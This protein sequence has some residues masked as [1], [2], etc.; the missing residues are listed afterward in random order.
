MAR[1]LL[2]VL[3]FLAAPLPAAA[4]E[5]PI[6]RLDEAAALSGLAIRMEALAEVDQFSGAFL[7]AR[8]DQVLLQQAHGF[9]DRLGVDDRLLVDRVGR[10][11]FR[12]IRLHPITIA[13]FRQLDEL[14]R[15]RR[16]VEP[17]DRS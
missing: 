9:A 10:G 14:D 15:G 3:L 5:P 1:W 6:E 11:R 17:D 7:V 4:D 2:T 12:R 16:D 13:A 8:H